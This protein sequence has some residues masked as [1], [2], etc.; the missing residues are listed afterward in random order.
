L[1]ELLLYIADR[2]QHYHEIIAPTMQ[3]GG[4]VVCDRYADST[5]AYQGYGRGLD[6]HEILQLNAIAARH[7]EPDL[8]FLFDGAPRELL[9]RAKA[10]AT[11]A[12]TTH[13]RMEQ[14]NMAFYERVA[15]GFRDI[16]R[17][18]PGRVVVLDAMAS[19]E[20]LHQQVMKAVFAKLSLS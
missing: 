19:I 5:L 7:R 18:T 12:A 9:S 6:H 14:E 11:A 13:D 4:I 1:C 20:S 15:E 2:A 17:Q 10:R 8:T 16:S 3:E